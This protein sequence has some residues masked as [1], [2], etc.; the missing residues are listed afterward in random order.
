[1]TPIYFSFENQEHYDKFFGKIKTTSPIIS[2]DI[3][4]QTITSLSI[5]EEIKKYLLFQLESFLTYQLTFENIY[6]FKQVK[7]K[8]EQWFDW[9]E[10]ALKDLDKYYSILFFLRPR[11]IYESY[12][13]TSIRKYN[14]D[15]KDYLNKWISHK[16]TLSEWEENPDFDPLRIAKDHKV[17]DCDYG[18][19]VS[20]RKH[21]YNQKL[22]KEIKKIE[23]ISPVSRHKLAEYIHAYINKQFSPEIMTEIDKTFGLNRHITLYESWPL[24]TKGQPYFTQY[25]DINNKLSFHIHEA[26]L[27]YCNLV[28]AP[29]RIKTETQIPDTFEFLISITEE[30]LEDF[31]TQIKKDYHILHADANLA[32]IRQIFF[33]GKV[34]T[35]VKLNDI[36]GMKKLVAAMIEKSILKPIPRNAHA[37]VLKKC[38]HDSLGNKLNDIRGTRTKLSTADIQQILTS[39]PKEN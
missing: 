12:R 26:L 5:K 7:E 9:T 31:Y 2:E 25:Y 14:M 32:N 27:I 17:N 16:Y 36:A 30:Q 37:K 10:T 39:L 4:K 23:A 15:L 24:I 8:T 19:I 28:P 13:F 29:F 18:K 3:F 35:I 1:M 38:F 34:T 21:L 6:S 33:G 22:K 11:D 20:Y